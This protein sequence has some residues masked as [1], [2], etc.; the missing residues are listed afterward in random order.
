MKT[1]PIIFQ[2][3]DRTSVISLIFV[4]ISATLGVAIWFGIVSLQRMLSEAQGSVDERL[5][6]LEH[7]LE[8][9]S[10]AESLADQLR[11]LQET[12][13]SMRSKLP[14]TA[15]ESEFLNQLS[16]MAVATGVSISDYRPGGVS[17]RGDC[18]SLELKVRGTAPY[19]S[20]CCWLASLKDLPR[21]VRLSQLTVSGPST[22]GGA[23]AIDIQLDLVFGLDATK[24]NLSKVKS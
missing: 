6:L 13:Q 24:Q 11:S 7:Q 10:N 20:L 16:E 22:P 12:I 5:A 15:E 2:R 21:V 19:A 17:N 8:L 1:F 14:E 4:A 18:K 23:C 9:Q 3:F